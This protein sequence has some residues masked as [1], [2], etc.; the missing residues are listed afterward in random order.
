MNALTWSSV[1]LLKVQK[2]LSKTPRQ[3]DYCFDD[4]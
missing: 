3:E 1:F 2:Q 4:L